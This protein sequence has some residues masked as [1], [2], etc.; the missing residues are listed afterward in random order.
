VVVDSSD[1]LVLGPQLVVVA[2]A[3]EAVDVDPPFGDD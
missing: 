3:V 1:P 2:G